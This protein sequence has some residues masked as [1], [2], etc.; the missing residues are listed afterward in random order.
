MGRGAVGG[1]DSEMPSCGFARIGIVRAQGSQGRLREE[2]NMVAHER[3]SE[4]VSFDV[5][6]D[7]V[8]SIS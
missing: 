2:M 6:F 7:A 5:T 1:S 3:P 8:T 4:S